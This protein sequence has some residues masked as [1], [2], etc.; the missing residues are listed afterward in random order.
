MG[1]IYKATNLI[2]G[3][4]Y[5]GKTKNTLLYRQRNHINKAIRKE[6]NSYFHKAL[7]KYGEENFVWEVLKDENNLENLNH[8]E[9]KYI[10]NF[11]SNNKEY[12]YNL[13]IGGDGSSRERT[14]EEKDKRSTISKQMWNR[15]GFKEKMSN[16]FKERSYKYPEQMERIKRISKNSALKRTGTK[17]PIERARKNSIQ[18]IFLLENHKTNE[19]YKGTLYDWYC[20]RNYNKNSAITGIRNKYGYKG[21][22]IKELLYA[23]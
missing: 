21:W 8:L 7:K 15:K 11:N 22:K 1:L 20:E 13:T 4:V 5:I 10:K 16:I 12:G 3:K 17:Y 2:N 9:K 6:G 23:T 14:I 18:D 19:I